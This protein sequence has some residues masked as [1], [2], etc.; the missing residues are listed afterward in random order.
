M[1]CSLCDIGF[2]LNENGNCEE[3][4]NYIEGCLIPEEDDTTLCK[5]CMP[6]YFMTI[7]KLC[8]EGNYTF[9]TWFISN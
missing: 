1:Q 6:D 5:V 2:I 9:E 7:D 3:D 8:V 4:P